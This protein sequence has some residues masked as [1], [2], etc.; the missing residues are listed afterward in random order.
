M[1]AIT[2]RNVTGLGGNAVD[3]MG[4]A[5]STIKSG[6]QG[7][8]SAMDA[9]RQT[10]MN[11]D[12]R[13]LDEQVMSL[14]HSLQNDMDTLKLSARELESDPA[15]F[16]INLSN[17]TVQYDSDENIAKALDLDLNTESGKKAVE[18]YK[19]KAALRVQA[20]Q[21]QL[22]AIPSSKELKKQI[23]IAG[24]K[25]GDTNENIEARYNKLTSVFDPTP[26]P[27]ALDKLEIEN[28]ARAN[29]YQI[30]SNDRLKQEQL[31]LLDEKL[32]PL[33]AKYANLSGDV[34]SSVRKYM[35]GVG[36]NKDLDDNEINELS[37]Q[38]DKMARSLVNDPKYEAEMKLAEEM[39]FYNSDTGVFSIPA[40][41]A[42]GAI[43]YIPLDEDGDVKTWREEGKV[44]DG[45]LQALR[46]ISTV[47]GMKAKRIGIE[48]AFS[49]NKKKLQEEMGNYYYN[50]SSAISDRSQYFPVDTIK[51][52]GFQLKQSGK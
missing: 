12:Q 37:R 49:A 40:E 18:G 33:Q 50:K 23:E 19:G 29:Q 4:E 1:A 39:G 2:W 48:E 9:F 45:L 21:E 31:R 51:Q 36:Y 42:V 8:G 15:I 47:R 17:G 7:L 43:S 32:Q 14:K 6:F 27:T 3:D 5:G 20:L 44:R 28:E 35:G 24:T 41:L 11:R 30:E 34:Y 16:N 25:I 52:N 38:M 46:E 26:T 10:S 13:A 22:D